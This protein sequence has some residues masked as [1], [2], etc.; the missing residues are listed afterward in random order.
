MD[1]TIGTNEQGMEEEDPSKDDDDKTIR[2]QISPATLVMLNQ[3]YA[4]EPFPSTEVR[5]QLAAKLKA[6]PRQVQTWFQN[7]RARERRLG[8]TVN[9][10]AN[11]ATAGNS[12]IS[13]LRLDEPDES[14][15]EQVTNA[16]A[17]KME[18][19]PRDGHLAAARGAR[20]VGAA[21][22]WATCGSPGPPN[23]PCP[24][25]QPGCTGCTLAPSFYP[26]PPRS[27]I[28]SSS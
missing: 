3:V 13:A 27:I 11:A 7:R 5:K 4:L 16:A 22:S 28:L 10:P 23:P 8:G 25:L 14:N 18:G 21:L 2:W 12:V 20:Q 6:H 24:L 17:R 19:A 1:E 26:R 9:K 15:A